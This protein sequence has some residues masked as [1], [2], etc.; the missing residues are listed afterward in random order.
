MFEPIGRCRPDRTGHTGLWLL[1][2]LRP[3]STPRELAPT[4]E[5]EP[6]LGVAVAFS[7]PQGWSHSPELR[8]LI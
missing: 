2:P 8:G 7:P 3:S 5:A 4:P 1:R 6:L